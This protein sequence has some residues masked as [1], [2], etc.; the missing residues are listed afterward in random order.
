MFHRQGDGDQWRMLSDHRCQ[1]RSA[2]QYG[3]ELRSSRA[4]LPS[5]IVRIH[6]LV[7]ALKMM[8]TDDDDNDNDAAADDDGEQGGEEEGTYLI[9]CR[10][11]MG[12]GYGD[13]LC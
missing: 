3:A 13:T 8:V 4:E 7:S 6:V 2:R 9:I 11:S 5:S 12:E 10:G 1:D